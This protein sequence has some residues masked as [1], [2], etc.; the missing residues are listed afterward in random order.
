MGVIQKLVSSNDGRFLLKVQKSCP[1][2]TSTQLVMIINIFYLFFCI[3]IHV[4]YINV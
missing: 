4:Q 3:H 1:D 2:L